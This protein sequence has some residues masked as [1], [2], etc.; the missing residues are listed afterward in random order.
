M[1][2]ER[3]KGLPLFYCNKRIVH[4]HLRI[5]GNGLKFLHLISR[6]QSKIE[7]DNISFPFERSFE[8]E[9]N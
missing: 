9:N 4:N 6:L 2:K 3:K 1:K 5:D 7:T 8:E